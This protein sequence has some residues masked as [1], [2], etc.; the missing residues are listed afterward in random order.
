MSVF[1]SKQLTVPSLDKALS[2]YA[3]GESV[4]LNVNGTPTEFLV[5]QQGLPSTAYD[6]SCDG[7]WLLM[8]DSYA[9]MAFDATDNNYGSSDAHAYVNNTFFNLFDS[10]IQAIV[11]QVKI[12]YTNGT[13]TGGSLKTGANGL[14]TKVFLL[15]HIEVI[16]TADSNVNTE[17][18][19]LDYFVTGSTIANYNGAAFR[20]WARSPHKSGTGSYY[21]CSFGTTNKSVGSNAYKNAGGIRPCIIL[22][23]GTE[24]DPDTNEVIA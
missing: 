4:F 15:S 14:S 23:Y 18:A 17:G 1:I 21:A 16:G 19:L 11:K 8:K 7:T 5:V 9:S 12:P 24:F 2:D 20:W 6:A 22:P 3:V 10:N 13:G